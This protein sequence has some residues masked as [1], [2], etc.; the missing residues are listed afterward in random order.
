M[1]PSVLAV[2]KKHALDLQNVVLQ[3]HNVDRQHW[4]LSAVFDGA[5][6][7]VYD[8]LA[9]ADKSRN[10]IDRS[11]DLRRQLTDLYHGLQDQDGEIPVKFHLLP[12]QANG[13]DCGIHVLAYIT[14]IVFGFRPENINL[15][16]RSLRQHLSQVIS[17]QQLS[18]FPFALRVSPV[19]FIPKTLSVYCCKKPVPDIYEAAVKWIVCVKCKE[20]FHLVCL[21]GTLKKSAER[22]Y[23]RGE[24][25]NFIC[26]HCLRL[27]S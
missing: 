21:A 27:H 15:T 13:T 18:M 8:S 2:P 5:T 22:E 17:S 20:W 4:V 1:R 9:Y 19:G 7:E 24:M 16:Q 25:G 10:R 23:K 12:R 14:L 3:V 6:V 11:L 26:Q